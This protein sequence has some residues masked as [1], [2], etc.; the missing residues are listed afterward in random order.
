MHKLPLALWM[1]GWPAI[2]TAWEFSPHYHDYGA[3]GGAYMLGVWLI[4]GVILYA[5]EPRRS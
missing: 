2:N 4:G 3:D 5:K 1:V